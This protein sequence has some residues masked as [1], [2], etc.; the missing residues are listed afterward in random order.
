[1]PYKIGEGRIV[2]VKERMGM[3]GT[4][5]TMPM[6]FDDNWLPLEPIVTVSRKKRI[7]ETELDDIDGSFKEGFSNGDYDITITGTII[8]E[9][10]LEAENY[11]EKEVRALKSLLNRTVKYD[12]NGNILK[13]IGSIKVYHPILNLLGIFNIVIYEFSL[14]QVAGANTIQ[15]YTIT[16]K[17]DINRELELKQP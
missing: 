11:P 4:P 7:I 12:A 9:A 10:V 17:S 8:D 16:A 14:P 1:M 2:G 5:Y 6:K 13:G 15:N 3:M